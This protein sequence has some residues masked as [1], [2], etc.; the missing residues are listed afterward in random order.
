M[1]QLMGTDV[2]AHRKM[3]GGARRNHRRERGK[4]AG[5]RGMENTTKNTGH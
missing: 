2:E 1:Q 3:L 4:L 5:A